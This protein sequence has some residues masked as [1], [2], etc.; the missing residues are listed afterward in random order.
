MDSKH[1]VIGGTSRIWAGLKPDYNDRPGS[2]LGFFDV[3][4]LSL[5]PLRKPDWE[6]DSNPVLK[7]TYKPA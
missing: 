2:R 3:S 5:N 7:P 4:G 6:L 1:Y